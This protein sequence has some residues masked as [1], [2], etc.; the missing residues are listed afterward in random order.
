MKENLNEEKFNEEFNNEVQQSIV[1][2][3]GWLF[4]SPAV[5]GVLL[6]FYQ[7]AKELPDGRTDL[8]DKKPFENNLFTG[9]QKGE[10]GY[11]SALPIYFGLM[12]IAGAYLIK[13]KN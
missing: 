1:K 13:D 5:I 7:S 3:I 2:F 10:Y 8:W 12:A 11:T 6:F 9:F 4:L